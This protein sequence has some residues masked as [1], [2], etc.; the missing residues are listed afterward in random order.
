MK[1][2]N[3]YKYCNNEMGGHLGENV[4]IDQSEFFTVVLGYG[5]TASQPPSKHEV[6]TQ[7]CLNVG[8]P[9][10]RRWTNIETTLGNTSCLLGRRLLIYTQLDSDA[11]RPCHGIPCRNRRPQLM[12]GWIYGRQPILVLC[13]RIRKTT[14]NN[15]LT[16]T[17]VG[18][19]CTGINQSRYRCRG[20][21][22]R[23]KPNDE[24]SRQHWIHRVTVYTSTT[25][26]AQ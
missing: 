14:R 25:A 11:I 18:F 1:K 6:L 19:S 4:L 24:S 9:R 15:P 23:C 26:D 10:L 7:C 16:T 5:G 17:P 8:P 20:L 3:P 22:I 21:D 12:R 13:K 2:V